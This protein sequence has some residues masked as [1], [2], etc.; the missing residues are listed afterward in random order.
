MLSQRMPAPSESTRD[1]HL[2]FAR[3]IHGVHG[4]VAQT[5]VQKRSSIVIGEFL[6][7]SASGNG[8]LTDVADGTGDWD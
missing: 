2:W 1:V 4:A 3:Q 5:G 7:R 8:Y 6:L